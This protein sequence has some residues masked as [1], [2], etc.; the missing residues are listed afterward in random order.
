[1]IRVLDVN[2]K[3]LF[4]DKGLPNQSFRFGESFISGTYLVEIRQGE[5]VKTLKAVKAR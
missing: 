5:E 1:M 3:T 2:G 4:A